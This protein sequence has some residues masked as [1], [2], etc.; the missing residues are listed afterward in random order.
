[1][2][3]TPALDR[4]PATPRQ[5]RGRRL[6]FSREDRRP[7]GGST[8]PGLTIEQSIPARFEQ[9]A[10]LYPDRIAIQDPETALTYRDLNRLANRI[11]RAILTVRGPATEPV[12]LLLGNGVPVVAAM[13]GVLKAGKFYVSLDASQPM[14][15][16]AAILAE[17]QAAHLIADKPRMEQ[18]E[19]LCP[20]PGLSRPP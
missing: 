16:M 11:A 17:L 2:Y 13:L 9:Q 19:A 12:A 6:S 5:P 20:P 18:A 4:P 8:L 10:R 7:N 15:R 1:M 14:E 3:G